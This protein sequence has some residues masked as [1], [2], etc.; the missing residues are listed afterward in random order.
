L[1]N[2]S[3]FEEDHT[4][5][6]RHSGRY[7]VAITTWF[8]ACG[9]LTAVNSLLEAMVVEKIAQLFPQLRHE[10]YIDMLHSFPMIR[11]NKAMNVLHQ[12]GLEY[13]SSGL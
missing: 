9:G 12:M 1:V 10:A 8:I 4:E 3:N 13:A 5:K 6:D 7:E 11:P 2:L